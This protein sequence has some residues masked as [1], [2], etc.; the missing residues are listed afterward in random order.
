MSLDPPEWD[1]WCSVCLSSSRIMHDLV[2]G[3]NSVHRSS[4]AHLHLMTLIFNNCLGHPRWLTEM[5]GE[6]MTLS[7]FS[8]DFA[9]FSYWFHLSCD[10]YK[11]PWKPSTLEQASHLWGLVDNILQQACI[12]NKYV[13]NCSTET[14]HKEECVPPTAPKGKDSVVQGNELFLREVPFLPKNTTCSPPKNL[15]PSFIHLIG[16]NASSPSLTV[17]IPHFNF[18]TKSCRVTI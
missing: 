12:F 14:Y 10:Q 15:D 6:D 7:S 16:L 13:G 2:Y 18:F 4:G 17:Y 1:I 5:A 8:A 9:W 3:I 11:T